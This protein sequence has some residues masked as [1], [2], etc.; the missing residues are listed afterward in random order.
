MNYYSVPALSASGA[1]L[2]LPPNS[3][4]VYRHSMDSEKTDSAALAFGR[5]VHT[6]ALEPHLIAE[7]YAVAPSV[8]RR[9]KDGKA[10]FDE[11]VLANQGKAIVSKADFDIAAAM[12]NSFQSSKRWLDLLSNSIM[13]VEREFFWTDDETGCPCKAK[14]DV[15]LIYQGDTPPVVVDLKTTSADLTGDG[16]AKSMATFGYHRQAAQYRAALESVGLPGAVFYLAFVSKVAPHLCAIVRVSED[17]ME[18]GKAELRSAMEIFVECSRANVWPG[19]QDIEW[20]GADGRRV[21]GCPDEIALPGW[22]RSP[23]AELVAR[24]RKEDNDLSDLGLDFGG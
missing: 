6:Y 5:L 21:V 22:Y 20:F 4:A 9:S 19:P 3:P 17:A 12:A 16:L 18:L 8:D 2:L 14:V 10:A 15:T 11:F 7:Q 13:E 24:D 1:K 23:G